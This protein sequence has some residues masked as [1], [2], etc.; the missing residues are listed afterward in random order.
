MTAAENLGALRGQLV[1]EEA[2][3]SSRHS[4]RRRR[5]PRTDEEVVT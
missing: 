4:R 1:A 3:P 5:A 2:E